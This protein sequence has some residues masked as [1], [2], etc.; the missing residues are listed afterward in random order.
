MTSNTDIE[1]QAVSLETLSHDRSAVS[2][3]A[4]CSL[5]TAHCLLLPLPIPGGGDWPMWGGTPDRNMISN[6]KGLPT[7]WDVK[8]QD[9]RQMGGRSWVRKPTA[10]RSF[11]AAWS[12][13]APTTKAC[14][15]RKI[16]GDKGVLMAFRESDGEFH[17]ADGPRQAG[18]RTR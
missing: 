6:M 17:V 14:A 8:D 13:S 4:Y 12:S 18:R 16:T 5:P 7:S 1:A 11:P 10:T 9:Q 15:I 2:Q 3:S